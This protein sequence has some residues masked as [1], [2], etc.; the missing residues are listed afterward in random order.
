[1][2]T[3]SRR[4]CIKT[5]FSAFLNWAISI[6]NGKDVTWLK[7]IA[8]HPIP[9]GAGMLTINLSKARGRAWAVVCSIFITLGARG[10]PRVCFWDP[11]EKQVHH[12]CHFREL[13]CGALSSVKKSCSWLPIFI[14]MAFS[15]SS[16]TLVCNSTEGDV[17]DTGKLKQ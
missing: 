9:K 7:N 8:W 4:H 5:A 11:W 6:R 17:W 3:Y 16:L 13:L 1:M 2:T 10:T 15:G 12:T 14:L